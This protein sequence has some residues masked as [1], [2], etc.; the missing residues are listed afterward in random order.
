[1]PELVNSVS[2]ATGIMNFIINIVTG[3]ISWVQAMPMFLKVCVVLIGCAVAY[4]V[5]EFKYGVK[6]IPRQIQI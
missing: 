3:F 5:F 4:V 1:M 6:Q 2:G